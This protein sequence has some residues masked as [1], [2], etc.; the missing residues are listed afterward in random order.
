MSG[1]L[2]LAITV[3][4]VALSVPA[5]SQ[6]TVPAPA[7]DIGSS[8]K[9]CVIASSNSAASKAPIAVPQTQGSKKPFKLVNGDPGLPDKAAPDGRDTLND[10]I[11]KQN[12][13]NPA[14]GSQGEG[15]GPAS[16]SG[17][18]SASSGNYGGRTGCR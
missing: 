1:R 18:G 17:S 3:V 10:Q 8:R 16:G 9:P 6:Q 14:H 13:A 2:V 4:T 11:D 12:D 15:A 7:P 5:W